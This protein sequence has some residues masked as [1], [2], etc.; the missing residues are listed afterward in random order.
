MPAPVI[1]PLA[2][3]VWIKVASLIGF[4]FMAKK[5][6]D[7]SKEVD[8]YAELEKKI[9]QGQNQGLNTTTYQNELNKLAE[10]FKKKDKSGKAK[11]KKLKDALEQDRQDYK[12]ALKDQDKKRQKELEE[13]HR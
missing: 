3:P 6:L 11:L 4:G 13:A 2:I 9:T 12:E 10:D 1:A 5:H 7:G 8:R